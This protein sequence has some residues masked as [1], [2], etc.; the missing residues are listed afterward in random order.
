ME[1]MIEEEQS[2]AQASKDS[3][4]KVTERELNQMKLEEEVR[5]QQQKE[6][7]AQAYQSLQQ[8]VEQ[9]EQKF[10]YDA[11]NFAKF[12]QNERK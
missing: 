1:K 8:S 11:T 9:D 7:A 2:L 12:N 10:G 3:G 6:E 5:K 4:H